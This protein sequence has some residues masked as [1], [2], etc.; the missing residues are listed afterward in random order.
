[1][2]DNE[3]PRVGLKRKSIGILTPKTISK[4]MKFID[5]TSKSTEFTENAN[6]L[7]IKA[8]DKSISKLEYEDETTS[9]VPEKRRVIEELKSELKNSEQVG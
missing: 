1:M 4:K 7:N 9:N 2:S 8:K 6:T 3:N 5:E